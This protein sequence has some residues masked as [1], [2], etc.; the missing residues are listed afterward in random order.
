MADPNRNSSDGVNPSS[1]FEE[2]LRAPLAHDFFAALRRVQADGSTPAFGT[3]LRPSQESVRL[4]QEPSLAFAPSAIHRARWEES[5]QRLELFL[6]FTGLLGPNGA[7][8]IHL[9]EYVIDRKRHFDDPTLE[10]FLNLF[11]HRIYTL[12]FRA[13][14][15]NQPVVDFDRADQRRH[16]FYIR[17][18]LGLGTGGTENRD[19]VPDAARLFN[20]G[21]LGGQNRSADGL[22][23]ILTDF[24][25]VPVTVR[26]FQGTWLELPADS[27]CRLGASRSTGV[28]GQTCFAGDR[29]WVTHLKFRLRFGPL[30]RTQ[31]ER[32]LPGG[33]AFQQV[34]DWI[35]FY[36]GEE[37]SW[38]A[39]LIL[40]RTE[41]PPCQLGAGTRLGWTSWLGEP[42]AN[43]DIDDLVVQSA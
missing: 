16:S 24:L 2:L 30:D 9:T 11:Q 25:R 12:F 3:A 29:I 13:W 27:R 15:L 39:Q 17:S 19:S 10:A 31:Y 41:V 22:S 28:L 34:R 23:A 6:Q 21:W 18:L 36:V 42:N 37:F 1:R 4:A 8:P 32:L 14:A 7:L 5:K 35:R 43:R 20:G 38:E 40:R 33:E 26:S